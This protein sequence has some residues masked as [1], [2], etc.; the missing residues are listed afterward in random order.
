MSYELRANP[1][2]QATEGKQTVSFRPGIRGPLIFILIRRLL[3]NFSR[4]FTSGYANFPSRQPASA[5]PIR[6]ER[7]TITPSHPPGS[8]IRRTCTSSGVADRIVAAAHRYA[9]RIPLRCHLRSP[10]VWL[11]VLLMAAYFQCLELPAFADQD[12]RP[13]LQHGASEVV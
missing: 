7:H 6:P 4:L 12:K 2:S 5:R 11:L 10:R 1:D 13:T 9:Q 3:M 8:V